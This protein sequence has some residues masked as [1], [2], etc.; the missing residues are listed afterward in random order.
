MSLSDR[1]FAEHKLSYREK[2]HMRKK[3]VV[4]KSKKGKS[5]AYPIE[6]KAHARNALSRVSAF[7]SS[8]EKARVRA[9]VHSKYPGIGERKAASYSEN[10]FTRGTLLT[11][12]HIG[13]KKL[14]ASLAHKKHHPKNPGA[15][16]AMIGRKKF[17]N[18][19]FQ[20]M[21][22]KGRKSDCMSYD[23]SIDAIAELK[24]LSESLVE[25]RNIVTVGIKK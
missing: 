25:L 20:A 5:G 19:K 3:D 24:A 9:A 22:A 7:G 18:A 21:A 6:D 12:K 8:A 2:K 16:A 4:F 13:F 15:V 23:E 17:G 1:I 10:T 14:K 11:E